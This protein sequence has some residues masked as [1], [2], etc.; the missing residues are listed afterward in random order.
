MGLRLG[1]LMLGVCAGGLLAADAPTFEITVA[2]VLTKTCTPCH[3]ESLAS[4]DLV[5]DD[6]TKRASLTANREGW[7]IILQK[8]RA[9]EMPPKGVPR[10]TQ[11]DAVIQYV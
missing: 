2:P 3:N 9:G 8:L 1:S 5:I 10:P 7:E 6:F 11:L 4:G